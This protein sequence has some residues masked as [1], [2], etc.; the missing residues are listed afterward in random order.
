MIY[1]KTVLLILLTLITVLLL[2]SNANA[3]IFSKM[4]VDEVTRLYNKGMK[5]SPDSE[6][7]FIPRATLICNSIK[8]YQRAYS[9]V[10]SNGGSATANYL[11]SVGCEALNGWSY[12][13]V[14]YAKK[15]SQ[16]IELVYKVP[17]SKNHIT[18]GYVS[19]SSIMTLE[20]KKKIQIK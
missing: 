12:G 10:S 6:I 8:G 20:Q 1:L 4:S 11:R 16:I 13:L 5:E 3:N 9:Y 14:S 2:T 17:L 18:A 7:I 19:R 15:D